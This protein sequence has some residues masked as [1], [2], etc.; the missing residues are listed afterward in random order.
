MIA[1]ALS[2]ASNPSLLAYTATIDTCS[3]G[4]PTMNPWSLQARCRVGV[5]V[6]AVAAL[7]GCG[8]SDAPPAEPQA[9]T[10]AARARALALPTDPAVL[11][12]ISELLDFAERSFPEYFPT[13]EPNQTFDP[14]VFRFYPGT[15]V[16]LGVDG[17]AVRVL[18]GPF[19]G[20]P[21]DVG[22]IDDY[23]CQVRFASCVAPSIV[24]SPASI[25]VAEGATA[26]FSAIV[27]GGPSIKLQ[28][29]RDGV[30]IAGATQ[31]S[32]SFTVTGSDNGARFALHAQNARG[33]A[34][35]VA[36]TLTVAR[37]VDADAMRALATS[38]GCFECHDIAT[39][40]TG[41]AWRLV[42]QRYDGQP[43]AQSSI[44]SSIIG[45][46]SRRWGFSAMGPQ[47]VTTE[48]ANNLAAWIL[49]LK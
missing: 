40:R 3:K 20:Q 32:H 43:N 19:G 27:G 7:A 34:T 12:E 25:S 26:T 21:L 13:H 39:T 35:S 9:S 31:A 5:V 41:P 47:P 22:S 38:R 30:A 17:R 44:A 29:L 11:A 16:Y 10:P 18:G 15:G 24:Q 2:P 4:A 6:A 42:A 46:S 45:G 23:S 49:T 14:Y 8:G 36:A 1:P 28:W 37:P 48:E 33:E